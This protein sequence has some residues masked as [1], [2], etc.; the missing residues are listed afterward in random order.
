VTVHLER[1]GQ[2]VDPDDLGIEK[3]PA[4]R[5]RWRCEDEPIRWKF[6]L[7]PDVAKDLWCVLLWVR[8][9]ADGIR[10]DAFRRKLGSDPQFEQWHWYRFFAARRRFETWASR[11][12]PKWFRRWAARPRRLGEWRPYRMR[13]LQPGQSPVKSAWSDGDEKE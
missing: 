7:D 11:S 10:T 5:H 13:P 6:D 9:F 8:P 12:G 2:R 1:D 4:L 3:P